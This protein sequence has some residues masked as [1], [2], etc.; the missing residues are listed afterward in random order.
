MCKYA[1]NLGVTNVAKFLYQIPQMELH[2][3]LCP[4]KEDGDVRAIHDWLEFA[5]ERLIH[6]YVK[7][8][9]EAVEEQV[10]KDQG[11]EGDDEHEFHKEGDERVGEDDNFFDEDSAD[12]VGDSEFD[13]YE[14]PSSPIGIDPSSNIVPSIHIDPSIHND[15]SSLK[16]YEQNKSNCALICF[17]DEEHNIKSGESGYRHS[18]FLCTPVNSE[19]DEEHPSTL[20]LGLRWICPTLFL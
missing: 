10:D 6:I 17:S 3:G 12:L 14:R 19:D 9:E 11:N 2:N 16:P 13:S 15:Q 4:I 8:I 1:K 18:N 20:N 5:P 7:H